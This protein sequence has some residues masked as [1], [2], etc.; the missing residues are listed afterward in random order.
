MNS[1]ER[2]LRSPGPSKLWTR[3]SKWPLACRPRV[4]RAVAFSSSFLNHMPRA[5][6]RWWLHFRSRGNSD[7][8]EMSLDAEK[9]PK[10]FIEKFDPAHQTLIRA[11]R[12]ALRA[13]ADRQRAGVRQLQLLCHRLLSNGT[14]VGCDCLDGRRSKRSRLLFYPWRPSS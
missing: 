2:G 13:D 7:M 9:Q 8:V 5:Q 14:A 3:D 12:K 6:E 1:S 4:C 11:V 10:G